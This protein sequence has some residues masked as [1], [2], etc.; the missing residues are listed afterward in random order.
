MRKD[1]DWLPT[2]VTAPR[3]AIKSALLFGSCLR[4]RPTYFARRATLNWPAHKWS[5][6]GSYLGSVKTRLR[7]V[8]AMVVGTRLQSFQDLRNKIVDGADGMRLDRSPPGAT[9]HTRITTWAGQM[10]G[11]SLEGD[12]AAWLE[13]VPVPVSP[14]QGGRC[15]GWS[16]PNGKSAG[17][18]LVCHHSGEVASGSAQV[19]GFFFSS[20]DPH[21]TKARPTRRGTA[22][23]FLVDSL[24]VA[25]TPSFL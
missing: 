14:R 23:A 7:T 25:G 13:K 1:D 20:F 21:E 10:G 9:F 5:N 2:P 18:N 22:S 16:A 3:R 12:S 15:R 4:G 24:L 19:E 6:F 11:W 8:E 17:R